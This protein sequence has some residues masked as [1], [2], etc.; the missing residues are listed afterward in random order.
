[1]LC[2]ELY[3]GSG[4]LQCV[5]VFYWES[6]IIFIKL[7]SQVGRYRGL[8]ST[9]T[10]NDL[11][12]ACLTG[13]TLAVISFVILLKFL[14]KDKCATCPNK[15]DDGNCSTADGLAEH[16]ANIRSEKSKSS[17]LQNN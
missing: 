11:I 9:M 12:L 1:M 13:A 17:N 3:R 8:Y 5:V 16:L 4:T 7:S 15:R 2:G 10:I 6:H 14:K